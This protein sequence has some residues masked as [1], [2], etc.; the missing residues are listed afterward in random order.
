MSF[1]VGVSLGVKCPHNQPLTSL[2]PYAI[3]PTIFFFLFRHIP[4]E[5]IRRPHSTLC[6]SSVLDRTRLVSLG[7]VLGFAW[8]VT[9]GNVQQSSVVTLSHNNL[10]NCNI[11]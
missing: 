2:T 9:E 5:V 3:A 10:V 7:D 6:E 11:P 4:S 8:V 1:A